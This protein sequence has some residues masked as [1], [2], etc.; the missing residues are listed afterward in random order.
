MSPRR[1]SP[2]PAGAP[3]SPRDPVIIALFS[4]IVM[5]ETLTRSR[6]ARVLPKGMEL[7]H[8]MV[9][10][11]FARLGGERT[12]AQLARA[13]RL[14]RGAMSNT[15]ARL[16]AAGYVHIRP[17]WDDGR[18]KW[19]SLSP[20]GRAARDQAV[21]AIEPVFDDVVAGLGLDRVRGALPILRRL[22]ELLD[23]E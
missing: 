7:S 10:N 20:T 12:P 17:D 3:D 9:L 1:P 23:S 18:K 22:R 19:V 6:L 15:L 5:V 16:D 2:P 4:E 13:F 21:A 8:F 14:T 11:H